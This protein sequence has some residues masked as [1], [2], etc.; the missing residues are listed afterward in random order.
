MMASEIMPTMAV[1]ISPNQINKKAKTQNKMMS[2]AVERSLDSACEF[3]SDMVSLI[4]S[5]KYIPRYE[6]I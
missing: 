2:C 5:M 1:N 3:V 6:K 4:L